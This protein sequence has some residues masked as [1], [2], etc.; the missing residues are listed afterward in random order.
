MTKTRKSAVFEEA[1]DPPILALSTIA[2][3]RTFCDLVI[4][5]DGLQDQ[6]SMLASIGVRFGLD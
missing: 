2:E 3:A 1:G 5:V 6:E 4:H